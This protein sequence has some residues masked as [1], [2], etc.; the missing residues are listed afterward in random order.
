MAH[1]FFYKATAF[2]YMYVSLSQR[3]ELEYFEWEVVK[4]QPQ[5]NILEVKHSGF[6]FHFVM[7]FHAH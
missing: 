5:T 7:C 6:T 4:I 3:I 2:V 1:I